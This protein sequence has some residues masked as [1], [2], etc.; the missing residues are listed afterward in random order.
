MKYSEFVLIS[1]KIEKQEKKARYKK[2][3]VDM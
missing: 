1:G 3:W 2:Y